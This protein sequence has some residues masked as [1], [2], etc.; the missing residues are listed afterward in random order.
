MSINMSEPAEYADHEVQVLTSKMTID[1]DLADG[2]SC[3]YITSVEPVSDRGLDSNE[4]AELKHMYR[5]ASISITQLNDNTQTELGE[6][7]AEAS[8]GINMG[9]DELPT[10][11]TVT[12]S[13]VQD[14]SNTTVV[15]DQD[16]G[17]FSVSNFEEPGILDFTSGG[18]NAGFNEVGTGTGG[19]SHVTT[20][21]ERDFSFS[22]TFGTGPFVDR[23]DDIDLNVELV[24]SNLSD[25]VRAE[26]EVSYLLYWNVHEAEGGRGAFA[27]P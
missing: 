8:L 21:T 16:G 15:N 1:T 26:Y 22:D 20:P 18:A 10:R 5:K 9:P 2:D 13:R 4:L 17:V 27:R 11:P 14:A 7:V 23:T 19:G 24:G 3:E 6:V 12:G 25:G